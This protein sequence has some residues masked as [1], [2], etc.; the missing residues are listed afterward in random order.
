ML[1]HSKIGKTEGMKTVHCPKCDAPRGVGKLGDEDKVF[2]CR[3]CKC[4]Y[5]VSPSYA[6]I[7]ALENMKSDK[8]GIND[9]WANCPGCNIL[10]SKGDG[11]EHMV[12]LYCD[13]E[14]YW[15]DAQEKKDKIC[16]ARVPDSEIY[17]WW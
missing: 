9:G 5:L 17:R 8:I 1:V 14:F 13:H 11:C 6:I 10:I 2:G 12:C 4:L 16:H 15:D 7:R 3:N